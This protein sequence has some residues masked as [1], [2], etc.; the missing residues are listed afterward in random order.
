[1]K[2]SYHPAAQAELREAVRFDEAKRQGR[3]ALLLAAVH[4]TERRVLELPRSFPEWPELQDM[5]LP[6]ELRR[7]RV[8]QHPYLVVYAVLAEKIVVV[9]L[10]H[11]SLPPGYWVARLRDL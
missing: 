11:T 8:K 1:M 2:I 3:G 5:P 9:S 10:A 6:F 7:A 4:E